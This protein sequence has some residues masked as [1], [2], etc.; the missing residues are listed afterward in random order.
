M[1]GAVA[2]WF[3]DVVACVATE[4]PVAYAATE[5]ALGARRFELELAD[6]HFM[7]DLV[8]T[9]LNAAI[10]SI[11]TDLATLCALVDGELGVLD[12]VLAG[13]LDVTAGP[14]DLVAVAAASTCFLQGALRCVSMQGLLDRLGELRKER[15]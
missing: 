15:M 6:E 11:S 7:L 12:A 5:H 3:E 1:T 10:V 4:H 2:T 8:S 9:P 13:R 14:D